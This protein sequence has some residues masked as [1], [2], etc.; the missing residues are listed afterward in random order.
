MDKSATIILASSLIIIMLGM[1]LSLTK[2]DFLRIFKNLKAI[3]IGLLN[4]LIILPL[5][6]YLLI[7]LLNVNTDIAIGIMILAAC[8][9]GATSNLI[10]H[11]A[12]GDTALSVSLTAVNSLIT[13]ITIPLVVNFALFTFLDD[14]KMIKLDVIQTIIQIFA[15]VI[16]PVI[17]G[18]TIRH[19]K[20]NFAKKMDR[21][22]RIVSALVLLLVIVGIILKEKAHII[23]YFQQAGIIALLLNLAT[24]IIG[25]LTS[26]FASLSKK[27]SISISIESGI[28]NGT[29][30]I[31]IATVLLSST[32]Y[33]IAP[34]VYSIIMFFTG[35]LIIAYGIK[36]A[37]KKTT[38]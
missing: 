17:I 34:A 9:G 19:Y 12:K 30:A 18:M 6:A 28:Q 16:I 3:S 22:V 1:G 20:P 32:T 27:Q 8:P 38:L 37:K 33:A 21:P 36:S 31:A 13:I 24:M 35:G 15:I 10:T 2:D 5:I 11:L 26:K 23:D 14:D 29:M 25:Y 7:I 4:Q